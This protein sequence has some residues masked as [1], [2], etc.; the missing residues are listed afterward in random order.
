MDAFCV[1]DPAP[2]CV[3]IFVSWV[4]P[5]GSFFQ[6]NTN[7]SCRCN[8]G[9]S[10]AGGLTRDSCGNWIA[11]FCYNIGV[12]SSVQTELWGIR[13]GFQIAWRYMS[14]NLLVETDYLF[15][16]QLT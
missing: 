9:Y 3:P 5:P 8:H 1:K 14:L 13:T 4:R 12:C 11:G 16:I 10:A 7:V 2:S 6:L 15:S